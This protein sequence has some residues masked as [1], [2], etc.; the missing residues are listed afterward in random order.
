MNPRIFLCMQ[1]VAVVCIGYW[2]YVLIWDAA[3]GAATDMRVHF[4]DVGQG[5][6]ILIET[7]GDGQILVDAGRGMA[8]LTELQKILPMRDRHIDAV[9]MTHP[10]ADHVGG[11]VPVLKQYEVG[12]V[13]RPFIE[14]ETSVYGR[15]REEILKQRERHGTAV[16]AVSGPSAFSLNGVRF[17]V[18]W[19]I[20]ESVRETNAASIV[21]LAEYGDMKVLLTGDANKAVEDLVAETFPDA[22]DDVDI[23]KAGH[24]GSKTS[25][26]ASFLNHTKPNAVVYSASK[27]NRY[28]HPHPS[29]LERVAAYGEAHPEQN[30]RTYWTAEDGTV[31]FCVQRH[32]FAL[33]P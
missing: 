23:L 1:I 2:W 6:A 13:I 27:D 24:H 29:V 25:T 16:Y 3:D 11:F 21:L 20:G 28:G 17:S 22:T 31:S 5:D 15:V 18:L 10:D 19:P 9:I 14:S 33:C 7:P 30:L 8:V 12:T 32:A 26:S 4:L